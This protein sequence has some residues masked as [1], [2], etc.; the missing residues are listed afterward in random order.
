MAEYRAAVLGGQPRRIAPL[1]VER[2]DRRAEPKCARAA[3][4]AIRIGFAVVDLRADDHLTVA[5]HRP[6]DV[7]VDRRELRLPGG[8]GK[9]G[10]RHVGD[11]DRCRDALA[12]E[13]VDSGLPAAVHQRV[14]HRG[15]PDA[16]ADVE[17][18]VA[19]RRAAAVRTGIART[20]EALAPIT[21]PELHSPGRVAMDR[22]AGG[23][24]PDEVG[25]NR[26]VREHERKWVVRAGKPRPSF[27]VPEGRDELRTV[28]QRPHG[29][30]SRRTGEDDDGLGATE[31]R[32]RQGHDERQAGEA[33]AIHARGW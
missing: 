13:R 20:Q 6:L 9:A 11:G 27:I 32:N 22:I 25:R 4:G 21:G 1:D 29:D 18:E 26:S 16:R 3:V 12:F 30:R 23:R 8:P 17:V 31:T 24:Q 14:G 5:V 2:L 15:R 7:G 10:H 28:G 33:R 19:D